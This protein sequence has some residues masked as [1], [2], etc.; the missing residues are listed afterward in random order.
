LDLLNYVQ[1]QTGKRVIVTSGHRCPAHNTYADL[2]K[3]NRTSKHQIGA[4]V[5]FY[6]QGMEDTPLAVVE[7]LMGFYQGK[8]F[9]AFQRYEKSDV[10][11]KPWMNQEIFI[12]LQLSHE[13]RDI[14]NRHPHPYITLQVRYDRE[15]KERVSYDWKKANLGY[16]R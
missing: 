16:A 15:A 11:T 7:L 3:D 10:S 13:G 5:D 12:K 9:G 14:D 2:S 1:E 4:E 6:V 8:E